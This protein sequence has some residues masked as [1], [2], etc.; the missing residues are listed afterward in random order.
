MTTDP[1]IVS[2]ELVA[3]KAAIKAFINTK[4]P[5]WARSYITD[6][7]ETDLAASI[8]DAVDAYRE[9]ATKETP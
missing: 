6:A 7:E 8:V 5:F 9:Q 4:V 3:A 2:G 1:K